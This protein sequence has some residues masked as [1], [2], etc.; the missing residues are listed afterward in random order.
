MC[1]D[2]RLICILRMNSLDFGTTEVKEEVF[3]LLDGDWKGRI[4]NVLIDL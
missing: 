1:H 4:G 2:I 3:G